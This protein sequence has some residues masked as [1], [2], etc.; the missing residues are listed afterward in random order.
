MLLLKKIYEYW[1][2]KNATSANNESYEYNYKDPRWP[3][4]HKLAFNEQV[5][6][7]YLLVYTQRLRR[8]SETQRQQGFPEFIF[9]FTKKNI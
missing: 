2:P 5:R 8:P 7:P 6:A 1:R 9:K 3:A 4:H